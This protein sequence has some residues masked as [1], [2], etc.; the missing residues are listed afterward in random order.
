MRAPAVTGVTMNELSARPAADGFG[1]EFE[2]FVAIDLG[3]NNCRLLAATPSASGFRVLA[4]YSKVVRLGEGLAQSGR[5]CGAAR[6]RTIAALREFVSRLSD[7]P[8]AQIRCV[9][10]QAC[11]VADNSAAF[12]DEVRERTGLSFTIIDAREEAELAALGCLGLIDSSAEAAL[13]VDIGGG[14]VEAIWAR[15]TGAVEFF[16]SAPVG[17]SILSERFARAP[18]GGEGDYDAMVAAA[19]ACFADAATQDQ[20]AMLADGRAHVIGTSGTVTGLAG[21]HLGL[22]R[23]KRSKVDGVWLSDEACALATRRMREMNRAE[24]AAHPCIG[25]DRADFVLA[26]CAI[27][28]GVLSVWPCPRIRVADRGLREGVLMRMI[29]ARA[30]ERAAHERG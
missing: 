22:T 14:S 2:V 5:L 12:L 23:Y 10:T 13:I 1:G 26:G 7:F 19:R 29:A 24:R 27:L 11:R 3:T 9:A 18:E 30:A 15:R 6:A 4:G 21:V 16:H 25:P 8:R 17:V 20:R 28:E